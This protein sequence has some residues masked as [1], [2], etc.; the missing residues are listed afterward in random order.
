VGGGEGGWT[1]KEGEKRAGSWLKIKM[2]SKKMKKQR[3]RKKATK[4]G[5]QKKRDEFEL[6]KAGR[7]KE[8]SGGAARKVKNCPQR[9]Q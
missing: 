9:K 6:E 5:G 3:E 8:G 2:R 4:K 1:S 7:E